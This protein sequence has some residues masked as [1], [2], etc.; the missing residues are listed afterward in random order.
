MPDEFGP[1]LAPVDGGEITEKL[2]GTFLPSAAVP[3][4]G[5]TAPSLSK[6]EAEFSNL[7]K[8]FRL[9]EAH[10]DK[11]HSFTNREID[12]GAR[13][14]MGKLSGEEKMWIKEIAER[15]HKR[16]LWHCLAGWLRWAQENGMANAPVF[17][18]S[19]DTKTSVDPNMSTC[20]V[21]GTFFPPKVYGQIVCTGRCG[22]VLDQQKIRERL[23]LQEPPPVTV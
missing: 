18:S 3:L 17:D 9:I 10:I 22:A 6:P 8:A 20:I 19:W 13:L 11:G 5:E 12:V 23:A 14:V 16:P 1:M 15:I 4:E 2:R 7:E 21:C